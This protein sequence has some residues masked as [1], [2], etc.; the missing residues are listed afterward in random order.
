[1][2]ALRFLFTFLLGI[3][4]VG[5]V[6]AQE[7]VRNIRMRALDAGQLEVIY[8]LTVARPGDS[9]YLEVRSRL[10]GTLRILPE[11]VRGDIGTRVTVGADRRIVWNAVA[12]G[13]PLNEEIRAFVQVKTNVFPAVTQTPSVP[14]AVTTPRSE[15]VA[16]KP[17]PIE[18]KVDVATAETPKTEEPKSDRKRRREKPVAVVADTTKPKSADIEPPVAQQPTTPD[19][20]ARRPKMRYVGPLWGVVS[21]VAPGIGNIFVQLPKPRVGLRPLLTV[22][23][24]GLV[25]YGLSERQKSQDVYKVYQEQKNLSAGEPYYQTANDHYHKYFLATRGAMI[26]AA[27]DVI[28]TVLRGVRNSHIQKEAARYQGFTVQPGVQ[29]GQPTAVVRYS[30]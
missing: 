25:A 7:R 4:L 23:C 1:M 24:Y 5:S 16:P 30:F 9:I 14:P 2:P 12:N 26:M 13:Y 20:T 19:D 18:P 15:T 10:R 29:A 17:I 3:L 21:A 6:Q 22:A 11:Y 27:A 8:D 28:L